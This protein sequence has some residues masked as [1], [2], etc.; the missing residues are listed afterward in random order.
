MTNDAGGILDDVLLYGLQGTS[1]GHDAGGDAIP[2]LLVVNASNRQ[3]I[4]DWIT[5]RSAGPSTSFAPTK[6][7]HRHDRRARPRG[8]EACD[9]TLLASPA[10][11]RC[12][13]TTATRC[14]S[15]AELNVVS[16]TG[17]TGEDGFE[18]IVPAAAA[19]DLWEKLLA[20]GRAARTMPV[21]LGAR[22]TLRL[23]AAHAALRP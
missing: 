22:D 12:A 19:T 23:E 15:G 21:G 18:L 3:K 16:R 7:C 20:A 17:Y 2:Y 4:V 9:A 5:A 11:S 10:W 14:G 1:A 13:I 6:L 8:P